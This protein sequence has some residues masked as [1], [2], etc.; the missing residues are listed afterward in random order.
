MQWQIYDCPSA[1]LLICILFAVSTI[2]SMS[3][4]HLS[5]WVG[6]CMKPS[7]NSWDFVDIPSSCSDTSID[8]ELAS[9]DFVG[10]GLLW[11]EPTDWGLPWIKGAFWLHWD[12]TDGAPL[13]S[14]LTEI[15]CILWEPGLLDPACEDRTTRYFTEGPRSSSGLSLHLEVQRIP[16]LNMRTMAPPQPR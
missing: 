1:S 4:E 15:G 9:C 12:L 2:K 8:S 6:Q 14:D 5:C 10:V 7:W 13:W 3:M 11:L 16:P